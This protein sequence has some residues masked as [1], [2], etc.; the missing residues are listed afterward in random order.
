MKRA[1]SI[2]NVLKSNFETLPFDGVWLESCGCPQLTGSWFIYGAPKQ[3]KT[4]FA[5]QLTKY[6][7]RFGRVA[8]DSVEEGFSLT[9]REAME[10]VNMQEVSSKVI[11]LDKENVDELKLRL[12][13]RKSPRIVILDSIQFMELKFSEYKE[14][15][16]AFP[17]KLF[18]YISHVD[19]KYPEGLVARKVWRDA[20]IS[21]RI[22][23]FKAFPVGRYG[24]G[25]EYIINENRA[26]EYWALEEQK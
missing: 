11:L 16:A 9:I 12:R 20:N 4:S 19:G 26:M 5:M 18:V 7:S 23:G 22:E 24:G 8:Y 21:F 2:G 1:Y 6:I 10:R 13:E 15:K 14:L 17:D 3:G 25:R